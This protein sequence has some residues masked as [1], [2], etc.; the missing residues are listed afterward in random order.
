MVLDHTDGVSALLSWNRLLY[1][2]CFSLLHFA[3]L[4]F[5]SALSSALSES[6]QTDNTRLRRADVRPVFKH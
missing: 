1:L 5:V 2:V 4:C 3:V 6:G